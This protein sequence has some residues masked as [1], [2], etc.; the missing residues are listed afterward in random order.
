M[1]RNLVT[2]LGL[3]AGV[4]LQKR[5]ARLAE[6]GLLTEAKRLPLAVMVKRGWFPGFAGT[7][8]EAR[9]QFEELM[10]AFVGPLG[11]VAL[12]PAL[13]KH[14]VRTGSRM[15][16]HALTAWRIRVARV[17]L[18]EA[19]PP[20]SPGTVTGEFVRDIVQLSYFD[21]GPQLAR[22]FLGKKGIHL[23]V[24]PHLPKTF[25]D[26]AAMRLPDGSALVALTLR[27]DRL[28]NFWFTLSHELAHLGLHLNQQEQEAYFDDMNDASIEECEKEADAFATEALIPATEWKAAKLSTK[29]TVAD[30][31]SFSEQLRISPAIPAGRLRFEARDCT[32]FKELIGTRSVRRLFPPGCA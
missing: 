28:D 20:Y 8:K 32:I 25:L 24:E 13:H 11:M 12:R 17:A 31:R 15:D 22:E 30:L 23:I 1:I 3:P 18:Q 5:G 4:L 27:Y 29:S 26:G 7:V 10:A 19:L 16:E 2:G 14:R 21:T 6:D 9:A